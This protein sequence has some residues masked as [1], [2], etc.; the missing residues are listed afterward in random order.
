MSLTPIKIIISAGAGSVAG[1]DN[2]VSE[3]L[4]QIFNENGIDADVSLAQ[5]GAELSELAQDAARGPYRVIVA[6]G[7]DGTVNTVAATVVNSGKILGVLPLG[8]LNHFARDLKIPFDLEAAAQTIVAGHTT[9]VDVAEVNNRVFVNNS[10]LGLYPIIV[11][12]REKRQRLGSGK[13]PAAVWATIQALR[14][15]PFLDV[16]LRVDEERL[17][18]T[19]PFVFIGNNEYAMEAFNIGLRNRLDRGVLSI[20]ITH[21][22]SRLKLISLAL[23]A[24]FGRLRNDKDFLALR[25][26]EVNIETRHKR[27]RV[28]FDGEIEVMQTPLHYRVRARALR[29]IVPKD[30]EAG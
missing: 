7:G 2:K 9:E 5:S 14:R 21:R 23:R 12:E 27:L 6:G 16:R 4:I 26:N 20:Y 3:R 24:V 19:T 30:A 29:V 11:R 13:W 8:T 10:S 25:S 1:D 15:Y 17:D 22:T 18:R 28:A